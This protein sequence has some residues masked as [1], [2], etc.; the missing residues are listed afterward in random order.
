MILSPQPDSKTFRKEITGALLGFGKGWL[1]MKEGFWGNYERKIFFEIDEHEKWLRRGVNADTLGVPL[2]V[3]IRFHEF[4]DRETLLP[5]VFSHA[6]VMRWRGHG[7]SVTF[8]FHSEN[9]HSPLELTKKW[10]KIFAG[11]YLLLRMVNF[12]NMKIRETL[13][14]DFNEID[15]CSSEFP[16]DAGTGGPCRRHAFCGYPPGGW[17]GRAS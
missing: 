4:A 12:R 6:P 10:C 9:W 14:K 11:P 3:S 17:L 16:S 5:F 2:E 7:E 15:L 1:F 13:W 8:E